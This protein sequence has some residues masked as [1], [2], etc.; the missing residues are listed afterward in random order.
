MQKYKTEVEAADAL[1]QKISGTK[2]G[3]RKSNY[4]TAGCS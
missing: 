4:W 2:T 3:D 1:A